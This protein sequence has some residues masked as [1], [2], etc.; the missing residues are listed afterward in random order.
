MPSEESASST[1]LNIKYDFDGETLVRTYPWGETITQKWE[2]LN[3][4]QR[5]EVMEQL[6]NLPE[7]HESSIRVSEEGEPQLMEPPRRPGGLNLPRWFGMRHPATWAPAV[8]PILE[9]IGE[10]DWYKHTIGKVAEQYAKRTAD[11]GV[12]HPWRAYANLRSNQSYFP[13]DEEGNRIV[14]SK[15][16]DGLLVDPRRSRQ[17]SDIESNAKISRGR[18][19][20]NW[21]GKIGNFLLG[22]PAATTGA[23]QAGVLGVI[24]AVQGARGNKSQTVDEIRRVN[25]ALRN[26]G[27]GASNSGG[28]ENG[29]DAGAPPGAPPTSEGPSGPGQGQ[30]AGK[31]QPPRGRKKGSGKQNM[32]IG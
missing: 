27:Q 4:A 17:M 32:R 15:D 22:N 24:E 5:W 31:K 18:Q 25:D 21:A 28:P 7:P 8:V 9:T 13:L 2:D 12:M 23:G 10:T 6:Y 19:I 20:A 29:G 11:L 14:F 30:Q 16:A 3:A 26:I 1:P